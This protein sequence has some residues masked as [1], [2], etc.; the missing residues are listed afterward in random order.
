MDFSDPEQNVILYLNHA[1][2]CHYFSDIIHIFMAFKMM[3]RNLYKI[4]NNMDLH[5]SILELVTVN[6]EM[7][8]TLYGQELVIIKK[9]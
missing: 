5:L 9:H 3:G 6:S 1:N 8:R 2:L 4:L 7:H